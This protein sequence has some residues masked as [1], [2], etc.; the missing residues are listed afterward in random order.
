MLPGVLKTYSYVFLQF[1]KADH[2]DPRFFNIVFQ[3]MIG[4]SQVIRMTRIRSLLINRQ[5]FIAYFR[6]M[7]Q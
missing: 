4:E 2:M 5:Q 6:W 7:K 1:S 3:R